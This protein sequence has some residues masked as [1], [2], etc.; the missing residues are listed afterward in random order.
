MKRDKI[1]TLMLIVVGVVIGFSS[2]IDTSDDDNKNQKPIIDPVTYSDKSIY[3]Q[4]SMTAY[5]FFSQVNSSVEKNKNFMISPLGMT[6][7]LTMLVHGSNGNTAAQINKVMNTP[8]ISPVHIMDAMKSLNEFLPKA[9]SKTSVAIAN[10]QWINE[11]YDVKNDY[12]KNNIDKLDAETFTQL[13]STEATKNDI[14]SWC[15][16]KTNGL[17]KDFLKSPLQ[18]NTKMVL[19]N[20][21]YF[22]GQWKYQFDKK[23]TKDKTFHNIDGTTSDVEMMH[24]ESKL[25]C[26]SGEKMD[27]AEFPYGNET[28]CMDVILPHEGESIDDCLNGICHEKMYDILHN[29]HFRNAYID[30]PRMQ[31]DYNRTLNADLIAMGMTDAFDYTKADF[32]G[33]TDQRLFISLFKQATSLTVNEEG[34]EAASVT[35][36][37]MMDSSVPDISYFRFEMNRPFAFLVREKQS[38]IILFMGKMVKF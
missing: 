26:W 18:Q 31:L 21:L 3:L 8:W 15:A 23:E 28:F 2:C 34:T 1:F 7:V 17:I 14:N 38:G 11:G 10:S 5:P 27:V 36:S 24:Q 12:I 9:D 29:M 33:I 13:L 22:K 16:R 32:S 35:S 20:A 30:M 6:E 4:T 19:L 25:L 37:E